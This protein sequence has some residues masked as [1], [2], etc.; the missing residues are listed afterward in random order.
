MSSYN[1]YD[2]V[3]ATLESAAKILGYE[4]SEYEILKH[5]ERS[6]KVAVPVRM[7]DGSIKVFDGYRVQHSTVRGPAKGGLRYH[8]DVNL[9]EVSALA[10]WM[11]FKC[12]VVGIPYGGGKGALA[13]DPTKLSKNELKNLTRSFT[14]MIA[15]IIG[16]ETDIPAPDLGTNPEIMGWIVDT[17]ST[18]KGYP[19][20]G[21]VTGKPIELGGSLGRGEATGRGITITAKNALKA[22][23]RELKGATVAVQGMGNVGSVSAKLIHAA[24]AKIVAVSD[25]ST[26]IYNANGLNI[27]D[28][29]AFVAGGKNL[30]KDYKGDVE[31]IDN[32]QLLTLDVDLLVPAAMENM[33]NQD[34]AANIRAKLI[35]EGANGP[36]TV[37]ADAILEQKGI[38]VIP[39]I[40]ANA[41]GVVVSYFEWVQNNQKF[42]WD[43]ETVNQRLESVMN[44]AFRNVWEIAQE[45][46]VTIRTGAYLIAVKKIVETLRMKGSI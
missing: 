20:P 43:E 34:N 11:T 24:G 4:P 14:T 29:L 23:G 22:L 45:K 3:L 46:K 31:F 13:V 15:P 28:I 10:A 40:L 39:D 30:L 1:P 17:Y 16:P 44:E 2:N 36:T 27:P 41:G 33:I 9:M 21:V 37:E 5:P 18:L 12:A 25:V 38:P 6:L 35:V 42:Y 19:N 32:G 26:G 7:D 8:P